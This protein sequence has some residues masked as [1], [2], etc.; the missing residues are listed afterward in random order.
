[1][2]EPYVSIQL[3][4]DHTL[5][6]YRQLYFQL[7]QAI[8]SGILPPGQ[9]LYSIRRLASELGIN[10]VTVVQAYRCLE[11]DG[12]AVAQVGRGT[13][14][15]NLTGLNEKESPF[16]PNSVN[17]ISRAAPDSWQVPVSPQAINFATLTPAAELFPVDDFQSIIN[18]IL[19]RDRGQAFGYQES[20]GY[21]PLRCSVAQ[22]LAKRGIVCDADSIQVISGAQQ[23]IDL[24]ARS[25]LSAGDRVLTESPT[26]T[27]ALA[28]FRARGAQVIAIPL[29]EDGVDIDA[30]QQ[31]IKIHQ[32]KLM[33]VMTNFQNPTGICYSVAKQQAL[34][35]ICRHAGVVLIED[36]SF[37]ELAY[38]GFE[39][40]AIKEWD[41]DNQ[42]IYIK[43]FSKILMPGLRLAFMLA[44][45][46]LQPKLM[47]AKH[48]ADISTSGLLQRA[49]D[50]Y[51][52][53]GLWIRHL[54][55]MKQCYLAR[56][57]QIVQAMRTSLPPQAGFS[58]PG[59]GLC[60]W[61]EG[62][63]GLSANRLYESCLKNGVIIA[64]GS[65]F[66]PDNRDSNFFRLSFAALSEDA[67]SQGIPIIARQ[68]RM[69][70]TADHEP[71][72]CFSPLL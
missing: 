55:Y 61:I 4:H 40:Q 63:A 11:R 54:D 28:S 10:T 8:K 34:A 59:G 38:D 3:Q 53:Q 29:Q 12:L 18:Q 16:S 6:L 13:F 19:A 71:R 60:I 7:K 57:K 33:Y 48:I 35:E 37:T 41:K 62:H 69:L 52:R 1:M 9:K 58:S 25:L 31:Q 49:F 45:Q 14:V 5:P 66:F 20:Q 51:L 72:R 42:I 39:R 27:G 22:Y 64:P 50:L 24:I 21:Y 56:Y 15:S 32:P 46:P 70:G 2:S 47:A 17:N 68:L 36:D 30:L 26:Y 23:G 43:S 67:I 65:H 44:P